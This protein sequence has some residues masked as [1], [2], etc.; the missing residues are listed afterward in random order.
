LLSPVTTSLPAGTRARSGAADDST[1][2][3]TEMSGQVSPGN[4]ATRLIIHPLLAARERGLAGQPPESSG[5]SNTTTWPIR[6]RP[7]LAR[8]TSTR[9][10]ATYVGRML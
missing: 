2:G 5:R 10:P 1:S 3:G 7:T 6:S 4:A 8:R 9:S